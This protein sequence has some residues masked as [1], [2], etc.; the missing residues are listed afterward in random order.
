MTTQ[1][2]IQEPREFARWGFLMERP[3]DL[4]V[5]LHHQGEL[6]ARFSQAEATEQR[7]QAEC[8]R[9]LAIKHGWDDC[10]W[11]RSNEGEGT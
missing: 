1:S 6:V 9:H 2:Q 3:E 11:S 7:L 10:L 5:E 8:A 4:V